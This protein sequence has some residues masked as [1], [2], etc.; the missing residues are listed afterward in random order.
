MEQQSRPKWTEAQQKAI[1]CRG[2]TV[3]VSAAAGS[4]KTAVLVQRVIDILTDRQNPVD[5]NC[6]LVVTF[7][8]AA[9]EEM[10]GRIQTRLNELIVQNPADSYLQR[11]QTLLSAAHISTVHSF[12][13]E[14]VRANFQL[15]DI[16][17]DFRLGSE[18][19]IKLFEEDIAQ[20]TIEQNYENND[21]RFSDLVEL[22]SSGRDDK[23]LQDTL[24][25]L[26][27][28]V[29]SHP[30]Y[31][32]WLDEKL[33][34]Y[35]D[36]IPVGETVW[37]KVI[38]Q[39]A[40][41]ALRYAQAQLKRAIE[42]ITGD[43][44]MEKAY[45]S[46][47]EGDLAQAQRI[48]YQMNTGRWD[49]VC[50]ELDNV[51]FQRLGALRGY[52]DTAKKELVQSLRKSAQNI[53]KQLDEDLFCV[54]EAGFLE[55]IR[56]LRPRIETLFDLVLDYDRRL[57]QE[58]RERRLL[59]FS[60]LEHFAVQLLVKEEK[61]K[62]EKTALAKELSEQFAFVLV[63]EYQDTNATQ[64]MIFQ[65]VSR[66]DNLFMVGDV[67]Q[68]IY[69]F[70]QAMPEIFIEKRNTFHDYDGQHYPAR[71]V[72][73]HNFRSRK[74]VTE[75]INFL[76]QAVM[77]REVGEIDYDGTEALTA[78][79]VYPEKEDSITEVHLLQNASEELSDQLVEASYVAKQ[80]KR[81]LD[82]GF[83][84][85]ES[86]ALR[87]VRPKD[88]C[89]LLRSMKNRAEIYS[90]ELSK[91][92]IEVWT[93]AKNGFLESVEISTALSILR[94]V[95]N[96]LIDIHL[97][98]AMMSPVY[99]FT[100]DDMAVLRL[101][102]RSRHLYLNC[103]EIAV[104][105]NLSE[106]EKSRQQLCQK[107]L[108]S[109]A[110][111]RVIASASPAHQLI[112]QLI[113][114][115]GL[116]DLVL[117]MKYGEVRK[118]NL[119]LLIQYA[120]EYEAGGQKGIAGFLRF[121]DKMISRG[122]D[123]SC[124][125]SVTDRSDA[126]RI[127]S[128]HHSKGLEFPVVFLCDTAKRFNTQDL[129]SNMLL[130]SQLGFACCARDFVTRKQYPT[131]PMEALKLELQRSML[132]EEMRI[133]YVALTRAKEKLIITSVQND[134]EKKL[135]GY[136]NALTERGTVSPYVARSASSY[137]DWILMSLVFHPDFTR[138]CIDL[139]CMPEDV[140]TLPA[141]RFQPVLA[142]IHD[143]QE[144]QAGEQLTFSEE[145][146]QPL[147]EQIR[148]LC[149]D[150]YPD[151]QARE[152]VTKLSVS[153]V[154]HQG[155]GGFSEVPFSKEPAFL[156]EE[157][158]LSG[159]QRGTALH[160]FM[161]CADHAHAQQDLEGE[162]ERMTHEHYLT[163]QEAQSLDRRAISRYYQSD[164]FLR[165]QRSNNLRREFA[166]QMEL[167]REDLETVIP[168]IGEHLVTVQGIADM[169]FEEDGAWVLADFK[170]DRVDADTLCDRYRRQLALYAKMIAGS[171][172]MPVRE[173]VIYS[174]Y[175]GRALTL[176]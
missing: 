61:G 116:W 30:F 24:H 88:I 91:Q 27:G 26:Y 169:I 156:K 71:I 175:L 65:S 107:F 94:A 122:E 114:R 69:R 7:S 159:A 38:L 12:C 81:M 70:R 31:R 2:G 144:E 140:I 129:R 32:G 79:A 64:D 96:P 154:V 55:D 141:C 136:V 57:M 80:I 112:Q 171:T 123:W 62:R 82:E 106:Q 83:T 97:T 29:R 138:L 78:A 41:D 23:G 72:L 17:A 48:Y 39:Y 45:L 111:L 49:D 50:R 47:F 157:G 67:K 8:N 146:Q 168:N 33:L 20:Q 75:S 87:P 118:A 119:R 84:V 115:T 131:V 93:D 149:S 59:D 99:G 85:T 147:V 53:I 163:A 95:D 153:Q 11:Q 151:R 15:L 139:G 1:S 172:G 148:A 176:S 160:T 89:I 51:S 60:D 46:A 74:E 42:E 36:T 104:G 68:S 52:E 18:N 165:S 10:R 155:E 137:A 117:A 13:L 152:I 135:S 98:A 150:S 162:I 161:S 158:A 58:K 76:F 126:V 54:D 34:M 167:G 102:D 130:H 120:Q 121:V 90:D 170:T 5:A 19:E 125:S 164:L 43:E 40:M 166:F 28:F 3:L 21:G 73:S 132:S 63:D 86:G 14:L 110:Q 128:V 103:Q 145:P 174:F 6:I 127:M 35:D 113:E 77:S 108:D 9:A 143:Q 100:A 101:R 124:A 22:V 16:P 105:E 4:G 66:P 173:K 109:F 134:L 56:F 44:A 92:G 142:E 133:L 25:R 37:G